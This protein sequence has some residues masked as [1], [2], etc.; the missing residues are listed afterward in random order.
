MT[1]PAGPAAQSAPPGPNQPAPNLAQ[2]TIGTS[3]SRTGRNVLL[4]AAAMKL[5]DVGS[6]TLGVDRL[7]GL[8]ELGLGL[9]CLLAYELTD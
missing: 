6:M 3:A 9:G 4:M 7:T 5:L 2:E 1:N 8:A